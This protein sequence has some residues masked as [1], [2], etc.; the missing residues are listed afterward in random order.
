MFNCYKILLV[1][2]I[3]NRKKVL[4][5][6]CF[7]WFQLFP[8]IWEILQKKKEKLS[9][10]EIVFKKGAVCHWIWFRMKHKI[11]LWRFYTR[12]FYCCMNWFLKIKLKT[13]SL[14]TR[15]R[16]LS[17]IRD[18]SISWCSFTTIRMKR[19]LDLFLSVWRTILINLIDK[20]FFLLKWALSRFRFWIFLIRGSFMCS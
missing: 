3:C 19:A 12:I 14:W 2:W 4:I 15:L 9:K 10:E 18:W 16:D 17:A 11:F 1:I 13:S 8:R 6:I 20:I 5:S 7:L